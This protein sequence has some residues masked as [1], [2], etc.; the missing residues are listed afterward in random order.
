[1]LVERWRRH[2]YA[3]LPHSSLGYRPLAPETNLAASIW[4]R[5]RSAPASPNERPGSNLIPGIE[6]RSRPCDRPRRLR[7]A[8]FSSQVSMQ[9][10]G[11]HRQTEISRW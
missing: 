4:S 9:P 3:V 1:V 6:M 11:F 2:Y 8:P 5:L 10:T 7:M